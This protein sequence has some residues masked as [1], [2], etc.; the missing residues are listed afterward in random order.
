MG[1]SKLRT[2]EQ[3]AAAIGSRSAVARRDR[4]DLR[5][6]MEACET[7]V[8]LKEFVAA[9]EEPLN[10]ANKTFVKGGVFN[11]GSHEETPTDRGKTYRSSSGHRKKDD[12]SSSRDNLQQQMAKSSAA[13]LAA[14]AAVSAPPE[15]KP[16]SISL[17]L[18]SNVHGSIES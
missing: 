5:A 6:K 8:V 9:F 15:N 13:A 2:F 11:P 7:E 14:A 12:S 3:G 4:G 1:E 16:V 10:K 18:S 17:L